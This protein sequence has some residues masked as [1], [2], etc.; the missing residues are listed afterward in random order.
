VALVACGRT[1]R[2]I[3]VWLGVDLVHAQRLVATICRKRGVWTRAE[4]ASWWRGR[5]PTE[6]AEDLFGV[7]DAVSQVSHV[8]QGVSQVSQRGHT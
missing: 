7:I 1:S 4:L 8:S 2:Q 3:G 6:R 5:P